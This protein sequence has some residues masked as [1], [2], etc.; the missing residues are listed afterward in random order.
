M[1]I[2]TLLSIIIGAAIGVAG[3]EAIGGYIKAKIDF[4]HKKVCDICWRDIQKVNER[5][6][7]AIKDKDLTN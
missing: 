6:K 5:V 2:A 4:K 1:D 3:G 7:A